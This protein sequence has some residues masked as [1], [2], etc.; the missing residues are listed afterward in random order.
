[1]KFEETKIEDEGI[2]VSNSEGRDEADSAEDE[3][4]HDMKG[5]EVDLWIEE[6]LEKR[7]WRQNWWKWKKK[8]LA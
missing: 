8:T 3:L 4:S 7:G 6:V 1:M 2:D 5:S